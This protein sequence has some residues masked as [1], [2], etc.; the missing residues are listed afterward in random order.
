[1]VTAA[2]LAPCGASRAEDAKPRFPQLAR[3]AAQP[4]QQRLAEEMRPA[5][6]AETPLPA[7]QGRMPE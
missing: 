5:P 4:G 6:P 2:A 3:G 1:M 7:V